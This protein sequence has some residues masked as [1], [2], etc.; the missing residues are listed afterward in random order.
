MRIALG[1]EYDGARYAGWQ[2]Q[3]GALT[4]QG[5]LEQSLSRVAD[6]P[7]G[8]VCAGRTD[9]GVHAT[10]QVVHF[11]T[12][13]V[14]APRAWVL[15][16]NA[17]LPADISVCWAREVDPG[18]HARFAATERRYRY[19][20]LNRESRPALLRNRVWWV[21]RSLDAGRAAEATRYLIGEHD[22]SSFRAVACQAKHPVRIV[23]RLEVT[24]HGEFLYIDVVAN[25]FLHHMVRNLAGVLMD[26][27]RGVH[28][29]EWARAVLA[30]RDRALGG[31]TAPPDGL[32]LV[33]VRYPER[34]AL[35]DSVRL[36]QFH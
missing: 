12:E 36:P 31:V 11:D 17:H 15:G 26:I 28:A 6:R 9:A 29:P 19:V 3:T 20:I 14:R 23:H 25:G 13:A 10:G 16:T 33:G 2:I 34:Y 32:Y 1:L 8:V 21:H 24:R 18:F 7:V 22:F 30:A 27:A 35:P 4:V 5:H